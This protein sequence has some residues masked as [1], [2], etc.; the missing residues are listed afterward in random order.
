MSEEHYCDCCGHVHGDLE[1]YYS[2]KLLESTQARLL[3]VAVAARA[4]VAETS[5]QDYYLYIHRLEILRCGLAEAL[6][7]VEELLGGE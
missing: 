3:A 5:L 1:A 7:A 4:L 2:I 6:A